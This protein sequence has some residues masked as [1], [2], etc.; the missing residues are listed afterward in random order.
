MVL[1]LDSDKQSFGLDHLPK[2]LKSVLPLSKY[3]VLEIKV[4]F[5]YF[6]RE[7]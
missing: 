3:N 1:L 4:I 6:K 2:L 7:Y 5:L